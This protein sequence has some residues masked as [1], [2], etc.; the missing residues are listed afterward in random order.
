MN[1]MAEHILTSRVDLIDTQGNLIE[2]GFAKKPL[3]R[4][5]RDHLKAPRWRVKEWDYYLINNGNIAVA[6]TMSDLGYARMASVSFLDLVN[7]E[8]H[9][10]TVLSRPSVHFSMPDNSANGHSHFAAKDMVLDYQSDGATRKVRCYFK[11]FENGNDFRASLTFQDFP[12]E[13]MNILTPWEDRKHFYLNEKVNNMKVSG[14]VIF[15]KQVYR[16]TPETT[17]GILDWG[18]GYWP[19]KSRWYWGTGSD[20]VN[21][22]PVG[23]NLGYGFGDLSLASE[24]VLFLDGK[25]HKLGR[26]NFEIPEDPMQPWTITSSANT[27]EGIFT[28]VLDRKADINLKIIRSNQNQ[29]FGFFD[30]KAKTEQGNVVEFNNF[31]C[32]FE[33]II[34]Q[35]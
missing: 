12:A 1:L 30:G 14:T 25:V 20:M 15:N 7:R 16:F 11:D 27:I 35:Y 8:D 33:D 29:Y 6:F 24:N 34:N 4:Y 32:S 21:G 10:K 5:N 9:T 31:P 17:C 22:K 28:P 19:Y 18:R 26:V 23:L 3:W 2:P 13:S